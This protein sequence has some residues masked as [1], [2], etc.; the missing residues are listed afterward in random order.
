MNSYI[1]VKL[2]LATLVLAFPLLVGCEIETLASY[3]G[4]DF[5]SS[6]ALAVIAT[7]ISEG[8][9]QMLLNPEE[10]QECKCEE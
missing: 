8:W 6:V 3:V 7:A 10:E 4:Y 2:T 9:V 1:R 5:W